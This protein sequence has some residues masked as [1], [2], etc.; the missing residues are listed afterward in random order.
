MALRAAR[1]NEGEAYARP[2][3]E[4]ARLEQRNGS[5][6][7]CLSLAN[8]SEQKNLDP[9]KGGNGNKK[10][11]V[12]DG[13][14]CATITTTDGASRHQ[15]RVS[16]GTQTAGGFSDLLECSASSRDQAEKLTVFST[17][18]LHFFL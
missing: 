1:F 6:S 11:D 18:F 8:V 17:N 5:L 10:M 14:I 7:L 13:G 16:G 9:K 4:T 2:E 3:L 15:L 12:A